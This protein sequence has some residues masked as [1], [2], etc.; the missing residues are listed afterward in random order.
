[1]YDYC[2]EE[3]EIHYE[4]L[5]RRRA[6]ETRH[7]GTALRVATHAGKRGWAKY[8]S[9]LGK[10]WKEIEMAAGRFPQ[11]VHSFFNALDKVGRKKHGND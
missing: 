11:P 5:L 7:W 4:A 3:L 8:T 6:V 10:L 2:A 9:Q 1:M